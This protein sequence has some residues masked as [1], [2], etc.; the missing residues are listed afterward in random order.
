LYQ[1]TNFDLIEKIL[2]KFQNVF[3]SWNQLI[4]IGF[5][6]IKINPCIK[7]LFQAGTIEYFELFVSLKTQL[8]KEK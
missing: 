7:I 3:A 1:Q 4:N 6:L 5:Y 2:L 8:G